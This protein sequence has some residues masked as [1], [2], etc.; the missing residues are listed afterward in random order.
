V[1]LLQ[2]LLARSVRAATTCVLSAYSSSSAR[3]SCGEST[4]PAS[5]LMRCAG[6]IQVSGEVGIAYRGSLNTALACSGVSRRARANQSSRESGINFD[7]TR[8][9]RTRVRR[10]GF[11]IDSFLPRVHRVRDV[12]ERCRVVRDGN[13]EA[14]E[15][16]T[17]RRYAHSCFDHFQGRW[18]LAKP[19]YIVLHADQN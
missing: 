17:S 9:E 14:E 13:K 11:K 19:P 8:K 10:R 15:S 16:R 5:C 3:F 18:P 2:P 7:Y 6:E 4:E 12:L 1:R